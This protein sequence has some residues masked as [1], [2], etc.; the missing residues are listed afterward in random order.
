MKSNTD[1]MGP[2]TMQFSPAARGRYTD[3]NEG[4]FHFGF[5][6]TSIKICFQRLIT[7]YME[8]EKLR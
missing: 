5:M 4:Q 8:L 2:I 3:H 7:H 6:G 1:F